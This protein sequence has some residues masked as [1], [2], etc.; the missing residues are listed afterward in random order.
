MQGKNDVVAINI[1]RPSV[2]VYVAVVKSKREEKKKESSPV[3]V[4]K[5]ESLL[6][7]RS[8]VAEHI[9]VSGSDIHIIPTNWEQLLRTP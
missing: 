4:K 8:D 1:T 3:A 5:G 7:L 2:F 6:E 9:I